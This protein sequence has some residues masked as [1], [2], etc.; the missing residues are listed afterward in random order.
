MKN[1]RSKIT[2]AETTVLVS[3]LA[4]PSFLNLR[5]NEPEGTEGVKSIRLLDLSNPE[6]LQI[7]EKLHNSPDDFEV[8]D[9]VEHA[10]R[11][12]VY[13]TLRYIRKSTCDIVL[14]KPFERKSGFSRKPREKRMPTLKGFTPPKP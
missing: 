6:H 4:D 5:L 10:G 1:N 14:P 2:G 9:E 3:Q 13:V 8:L 7:Y 11:Y 12:T